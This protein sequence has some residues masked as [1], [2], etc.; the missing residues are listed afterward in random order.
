MG[1]AEEVA[2]LI[3]RIVTHPHPRLRYLIGT[4]AKKRYLLR[5]ILP[6]KWYRRLVLHKAFGPLR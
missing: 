6:F 5:R 2:R 3:E 1:D 4:S